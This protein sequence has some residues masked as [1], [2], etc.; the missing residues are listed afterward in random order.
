MIWLIRLLLIFLLTLRCF[1]VYLWNL[2]KKLNF[3]DREIDISGASFFFFCH[4]MYL[5]ML[6][7][8]RFMIQL[9]SQIRYKL[10]VENKFDD[11]AEMPIDEVKYRINNNTR[12]LQKVSTLH[13]SSFYTYF[14]YW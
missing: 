5:K 10:A 9:Q 7:S 6:K 2:T 13:I 11:K 12:D 3:L 8:C 14:S 1:L 4:F